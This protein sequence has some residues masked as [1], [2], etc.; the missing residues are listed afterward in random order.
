MTYS[1]GTGRKPRDIQTQILDEF[2]SIYKDYSFIGINAPVSS[3]KSFCCKNIQNTLGGHILTPQNIL[4]N[5]Y[6]QTYKTTNI[7]KGANSYQCH[8]API[9]WSCQDYH[10]YLEGEYCSGCKYI[11]G[12]IRAGKEF[13][14][15]NPISYYYTKKY[16]NIKSSNFLI[17]DEVHSFL[18]MLRMVLSMKL[19]YETWD[20]KPK[21]TK[22]PIIFE[23]WVIKKLEELREYSRLKPP[24]F[25]KVRSQIQRLEMIQELF[26]CSGKEEYIFEHGEDIDKKTGRKKPFLK[27]QPIF[28]P[29]KFLSE[30]ATP[31][32][33]G[34]SG[35]IFPTDIEELVAGRNFKIIDVDSPI[36]VENREFRVENTTSMNFETP[37]DTYI[38]KLLFLKDKINI[39]N[40]VIHV[41][42]ELQEKLVTKIKETFPLRT[43]HVNTSEDK[44]LVY[45]QFKEQGGIFLAAGCSEGLDMKDDIARLNV[46][47]KVDFP[48]L[49]DKYIEKRA[50][51]LNGKQFLREQVLK[52]NIQRY[53]RTTRHE[54]DWSVTYCFD[55]NIYKVIAEQQRANLYIPKYFL[56]AL[57]FF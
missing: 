22:T 24:D 33:I 21:H 4:V 13:S 51:L 27:I 43:L 44:D 10:A 39:Y 28:I 32:I 54:K 9:G 48:N 11:E 18:S 46:I 6:N 50:G 34:T 2:Y 55:S 20:L 3:G 12:K 36:P 35:T 15:F 29:S 17:I 31:T 37:I 14:I 5:Q 25:T 1:D 40:T 7:V 30:Y 49:K 56:D 42:Y 41:S 8:Q 16:A 45:K 26:K 52:L 19:N 47:L 57:R 53:G 23:K 38:D